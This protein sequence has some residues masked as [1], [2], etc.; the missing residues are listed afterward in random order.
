M[1]SPSFLIAFGFTTILQQLAECPCT[2]DHHEVY[3]SQHVIP[4]MKETIAKL[5][6]PHDTNATINM[7]DDLANQFEYLAGEQIVSLRESFEVIGCPQ[8]QATIPPQVSPAL[9]ETD[10]PLVEISPVNDDLQKGGTV[11]E[12]LLF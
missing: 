9:P 6:I 12:Y 11:A 3:I 1:T 4:Y 10:S 8:I 2:N 7:S 5:A